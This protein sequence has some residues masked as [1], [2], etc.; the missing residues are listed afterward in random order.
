V[1]KGV[2]VA[3]IGPRFHPRD[4]TES[5]TDPSLRYTGL[6]E[7]LR[8]SWQTPPPIYYIDWYSVDRTMLLDGFS[9]C[10]SISQIS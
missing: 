5:I 3:R 2:R 9:E 7:R 4:F 8:Q 6:T 1:G 10:Q